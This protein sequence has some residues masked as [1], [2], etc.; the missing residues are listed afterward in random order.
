[1]VGKRDCDA[2]LLMAL[3]GM[4]NV[5]RFEPGDFVGGQPDL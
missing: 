1:M 4:R 3:H 5:R 2:D